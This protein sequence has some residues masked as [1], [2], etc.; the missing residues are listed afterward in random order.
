MPRNYKRKF[1]SRNCCNYAKETLEAPTEEAKII[2]IKAAHRKYSI[3]YGTLQ[4]KIAQKRCWKT[5]K[6][7][8]IFHNN[9]F[10]LLSN[11]TLHKLVA[12]VFLT[13]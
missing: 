13:Y 7:K 6:V 1:G 11:A 12:I 4:S 9:C 10:H 2:G 5:N 8:A 3:P